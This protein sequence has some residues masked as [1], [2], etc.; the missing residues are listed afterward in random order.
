MTAAHQPGQ[1]PVRKMNFEFK[2]VPKDYLNGNL[3][4]SNFFN[5]MNLLFPEGERFFMHAVRDGLKQL[6]N[7]T[8]DLKQRAKGFYGQEA[9]HS[10]EHLK[11]FDILDENGYIFREELTKFD[12]FIIK[13]R[14]KLPVKLRLA[15]TAGAEH[16]T[17]IAAQVAL[18]DQDVVEGHPVMRDLMQWH[19]IEEIEHKA[20]AYDVYREVSG[21]YFLRQFGYLCAVLVVLG[22]SFK[23]AHQFM[24]QDGYSGRQARK[25]MKGSLRTVLKRNRYLM[26]DFLAYLKPGF[27]PDQI[28]DERLIE[29]ARV[30]LAA[31]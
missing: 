4:F 15:M 30:D 2:D 28:D 13:M 14:K 20:V 25:A 22:Y 26:K 17:A 21:N 11:Y 18:R 3:P 23:F 19:A 1:I 5:G 6:D 7:P 31:Y 24:R 10:L 29:E 9:Q 16:L 8:E 27:H 12:N